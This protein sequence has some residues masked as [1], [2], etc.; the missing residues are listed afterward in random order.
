MCGHEVNLVVPD[1]SSILES[2]TPLRS[3]KAGPEVGKVL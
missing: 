1:L 2:L 3:V